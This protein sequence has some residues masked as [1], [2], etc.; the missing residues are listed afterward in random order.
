MFA[1]SLSQPSEPLPG[2]SGIGPLHVAGPERAPG[3]ALGVEAL[4]AHPAVPIR[5][6][7]VAEA[8]GVHHAV[9]VEPVI[10]A[11]RRVHGIGTVAQEHAVEVARQLARHR[12]V[13][14]VAL[15]ED[16]RERAFQIGVLR[17]REPVREVA[18]L[19][20]CCLLWVGSD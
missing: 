12:Q 9:A 5:G 16:R 11:A 10:A 14:R 8:H 6:A 18:A 4:G 1:E 17:L 15:V 13:G 19:R 20:S 3:A 7:P 2:A